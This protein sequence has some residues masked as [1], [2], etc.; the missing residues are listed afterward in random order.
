[1]VTISGPASL[2]ALVQGMNALPVML[3]ALAS[4]LPA[5]NFDRRILMLSAQAAMLPSW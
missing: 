5:D 2:V 1:M 4:D 3:F